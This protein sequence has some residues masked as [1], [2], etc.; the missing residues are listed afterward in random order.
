[1]PMPAADDDAAAAALFQKALAHLDNMM[2]CTDRAL[3][4]IRALRKDMQEDA[5]RQAQAIAGW[6]AQF[7]EVRDFGRRFKEAIEAW[8]AGEPL[9]EPLRRQ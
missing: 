5:D 1:M 7:E 6:Q 4:E 9:P 3:T 2:A 8:E